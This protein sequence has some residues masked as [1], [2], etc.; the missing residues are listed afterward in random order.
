LEFQYHKPNRF[1]EEE[2]QKSRS[3]E[4]ER[5]GRHGDAAVKGGT[6]K[7]KERKKEKRKKKGGGGRVA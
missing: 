7:K 4:G 2:R 3:G 6:S 1:G 5:R